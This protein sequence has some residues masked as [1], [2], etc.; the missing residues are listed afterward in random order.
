MAQ[1]LGTPA[2]KGNSPRVLD[3]TEF[4]NLTGLFYQCSSGLL[5]VN[6]CAGGSVLNKEEMD[7]RK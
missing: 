5:S 6:P 4:E 2:L 7:V 3:D 1:G